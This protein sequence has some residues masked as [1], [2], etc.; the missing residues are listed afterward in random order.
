MEDRQCAAWT[1]E[2]VIATIRELAAEEEVPEHLS[3]AAIRAEDTVET[4]GLDSLGAVS[5]I[6]RLEAQLGMPLPDDFLDFTDDV[7]G[8]ARR[9][10][11]L[12]R[13]GG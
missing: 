8:I 6:E 11:A 13:A 7:A 1:M 2:R 3:T 9:L 5:L 4:L 12:A 10:D